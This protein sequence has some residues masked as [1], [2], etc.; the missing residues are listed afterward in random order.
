MCHLTS[1][2]RL[3]T[4]DEHVITANM[5]VPLDI[6]E[7]Y[8]ACYVHRSFSTRQLRSSWQNWRHSWTRWNNKALSRPRDDNN[9]ICCRNCYM[10]STHD[11]LDT[12][13]ITVNEMFSCHVSKPRT[14]FFVLLHLA[15]RSLDIITRKSYVSSVRAQGYTRCFFPLSFWQNRTYIHIFLLAFDHLFELK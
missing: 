8:R 13:T 14:R 2:L 15:L 3:N 11:N 12:K 9:A 5:P 4:R 1:I 6:M 10:V 7:S